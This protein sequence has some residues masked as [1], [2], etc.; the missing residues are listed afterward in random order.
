MRAP[1][2]ADS[3]QIPRTT[4]GRFWFQPTDPT[5]LGFMRIVTGLIVIYVHLSYC[6]DLG[7]FFGP[8]AYIDQET[9]NK[10]R[11]ETPMM[12]ESMTD[13]EEKS[14]KVILPILQDQ[15][16]AAIN[17]LRGL[18]EDKRERDDSLEYLYYVLNNYGSGDGMVNLSYTTNGLVLLKNAHKL[19]EQQRERMLKNL[20][21]ERFVVQEAPITLPV[22]FFHHSLSQQDRLQ[23]WQKALHLSDLLWELP[24]IKDPNDDQV[25][26]RRVTNVIS[27]INEAQPGQR[28]LLA[29]YLRE[30]PGGKEG[31]EYI[32][33]LSR[34]RYDP[35]ELYDH[36]SSTFSMW[37][38]LKNPG[39]MWTAHIIALLIFVL[40]TLGLFTRVTS[41]LTWLAALQYIHRSQQ[42]LFGMDTMMNI[43]LFYL[44]I[45]PSGAAL[46]IDRLIA[47]YRAARAIAKAGGKPVP[48]A[49]SVLAG[50]QPSSMANFALRLLQVHFCIIYTSAG[51]A[52]LKGTLWWNTQA[53]WYTIAN[54]EFTPMNYPI[55][56]STLRWVA[57][58][59]PLML[60][61]F[62]GFTYF[63]LAME[64]A[65]PYLVWTR[66]R[67]VVVSLAILL[68]GGIAV[69][70]G[71]VSFQL[72]MMTMLIA[73]IPAAVIRQRLFWEPGSGP[74]MSLRYDGKNPEHARL[75]SFIRALDVTNQ[76]SCHD[77]AGKSKIGEA[78]E[79]VGVDGRVHTGY[80]IIQHA[81]ANLLFA[82]TIRW[83]L[84]VPG[85]ALL[86]RSFTGATEKA[87]EY[88]VRV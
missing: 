13:W 71:L 37:Y 69:I 21:N 61:I 39:A 29:T 72:L 40:F 80:D 62:A 51:L 64:I 70:M 15:R 34:W 82:R 79:L 31:R 14:R 81:F 49:E 75:A 6:Y 55:Y 16:E 10:I 52:K 32:D 77:E 9:G 76:V 57:S 30:L 59:K 35:R 87:Q 18:P 84:Y 73:Y 58:I 54:P 12:T 86:I 48:W 53:T 8:N 1:H 41:V 46:S 27:W 74:K 67:P 65:F 85:V 44:M 24:T 5:A 42:V 88:A 68:H 38:H 36:G 45:G 2:D 56:E 20:N 63:T 66:L 17:F 3:A 26:E 50:P 7:S 83:L 19:D 11:R 43:L 28:A 25:T 60:A 78:V 47:R 22:F 23:L 4:W 33:Y